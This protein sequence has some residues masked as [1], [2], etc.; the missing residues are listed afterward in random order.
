MTPSPQPFDGREP[1]SRPSPPPVSAGSVV[2]GE[3][4][5]LA[6]LSIAVGALLL[7]EVAGMI[8]GVH[9]LWPVF[10]TAVG[11][12]LV[13]AF[14]QRGRQDLLLLGIGAYLLVA[15]AVFFTCNFTTW[16]FL[17]RAWPLF[18]AFLGLVSV[19]ASLYAEKARRVL[20]LSGL[21]LNII[22]LVLYLVF[23]V[24]ERLWP[25][26]LVL[27]GGWILLVTRARRSTG[28]THA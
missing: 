8:E 11:A 4:R 24:T 23:Q 20:W 10:P 1:E 14:F 26:S 12:G 6:I 22:A 7:L 28:D 18:I 21:L 17:E 9:L 2:K 13:A 25:I 19:L 16:T 5:V 27:L 3:F 15:A